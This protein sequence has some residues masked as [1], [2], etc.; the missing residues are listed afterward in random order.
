MLQSVFD[1]STIG[2]LEQMAIFGERR[3]EVLAGNIA[4]ID[5]P[6]Y[7][8]RDLPVAEFREALKEAVA[9]RQQGTA[10]S[11][12]TGSAATEAKSLSELFP[13]RL[14]QAVESPQTNIT[15][16]DAN[17]RSI[18]NEMMQLTKN[19]MMQNYAVE[20]MMAQMNLLQ[21]VISERA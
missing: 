21:A 11:S 8:M 16:H 5:T 2:L 3:N 19:T 13:Q 6:H 12:M 10:T 4:N 18:E 17:N 20:L 9:G 7:K 1:S 15:F 14:F